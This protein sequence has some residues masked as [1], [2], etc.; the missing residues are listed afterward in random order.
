MNYIDETLKFIESDEMREYLHTY[1]HSQHADNKT[2]WLR[3][4]RG[5]Q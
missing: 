1:F 3:N 4:Q 5:Y 2:G